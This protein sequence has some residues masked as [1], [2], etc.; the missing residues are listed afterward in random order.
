MPPETITIGNRI[1]P[2]PPYGLIAEALAKGRVVPFLGAAASSPPSA[3]ETSAC[4]SSPA[5]DDHKSWS[6]HLEA[7][8]TG[9]QLSPVL[10]FDQFEEGLR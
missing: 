5:G 4:E 7:Y 3:A 2:S 9:S 8:A 6:E 1:A 10:I